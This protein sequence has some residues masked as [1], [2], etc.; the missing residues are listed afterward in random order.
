MTT[1]SI[2]YCYKGKKYVDLPHPDG[3]VHV[4]HG[5]GLLLITATGLLPL[6][7]VIRILVAIVAVID[8]VFIAGAGHKLRNLQCGESFPPLT[9]TK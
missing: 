4:L 7:L 9:E 2:R 3:L 8:V 5:H 6:L 1:K